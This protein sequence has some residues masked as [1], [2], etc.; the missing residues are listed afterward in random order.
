MPLETVEATFD[1]F[2]AEFPLC[3]GYWNKVTV[4]RQ[5]QC[6]LAVVAYSYFDYGHVCLCYCLSFVSMRNTS[7]R[8]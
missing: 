4:I 6:A 5:P 7:T 3:F 1:R 2:L 8:W